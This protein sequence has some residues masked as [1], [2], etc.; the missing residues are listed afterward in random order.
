M[1]ING[2]SM[3]SVIREKI[4]TVISSIIPFDVTES[5]HLDFV[6]EWIASGERFF[7]WQSQI[8][9]I[10]TWSLTSLSSTL[11]QMNS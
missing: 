2:E 1:G 5:E 6:K 9:Q 11:K 7:E 3:T 10:S 4:A 8:S